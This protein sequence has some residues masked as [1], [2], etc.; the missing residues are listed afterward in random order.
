[1]TLVRPLLTSVSASILVGPRWNQTLRSPGDAA[2]AEALPPEA[3]SITTPSSLGMVFEARPQIL[4]P[5][6][7]AR[8]FRRLV[9][10]FFPPSC[11]VYQTT[12]D[13]NRY[14]TE[15]PVTPS[16]LNPKGIWDIFLWTAKTLQST[17]IVP[18]ASA[19]T[20]C[21]SPITY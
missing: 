20:G 11:A 18:V 16:P 8:T 7:K 6:L 3:L 2:P 5:N 19:T 14:E 12:K 1:M 21:A 13:W 17:V 10:L 4:F 9:T 15:L